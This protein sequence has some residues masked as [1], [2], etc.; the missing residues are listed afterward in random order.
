MTDMKPNE[1]ARVP[2]PLH[3]KGWETEGPRIIDANLNRA[4]EAL[5]VME[6]F[7]RFA[8]D[9]ATLSQAIKD[10]RHALA[11][12]IPDSLVDR[13]LPSRDIV[14]DAG[15]DIQTEREY[16]RASTG[17]VALA[18][19][20]RL[21]EALRAIEEY[22]KIV[23][24][25]FGAS[26]ETLRYRGYE[27]EQRLGLH[28]QARQRF[29]HCRLYVLISEALCAGDWFEAAQ[30]ALRGGA[31]CLQL[32]EKDLPDREL[33]ARTERLVKLCHDH[34][35]L[36]IMNDRPDL[37]LLCHA[38]GVHVGQDDL[39]VEQARRIAGADLII[40]V[41]THTKAQLAEAIEA[42]PDY[43]AVG[44]MFDSPTK[45]QDHIAGP[46]TLAYARSITGLPL[47]AI[48]GINE[49]NVGDVCSAGLCC[50]GVCSAV[51]GHADIEAAARR[52]REKIAQYDQSSDQAS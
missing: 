15:R 42:A 8:L 37:A 40:G 29:G 25:T 41:S 34:D 46:S 35:A 2:G 36:F 18:A 48:G 38:D 39:P 13:L 44:P 26:V 27:L 16:R 21:S 3:G 4:R 32:R 51:I 30:A 5:R 11:A 43:V 6:D 45:P 28:V 24:A 50:I 33:L 9:D 14:H 23:D 47:V 19:G 10:L 49:S 22:G 12:A 52:L 31:D 17:D 20:K 1:S 7:A